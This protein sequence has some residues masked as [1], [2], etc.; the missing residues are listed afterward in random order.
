MTNRDVHKRIQ[1]SAWVAYGLFTAVCLLAIFVLD[2]DFEKTMNA[3]AV[4]SLLAFFEYIDSDPLLPS[5]EMDLECEH[6]ERYSLKR[7]VWRKVKFYA[8]L[9]V[10]V[11]AVRAC[12]ADS[13]KPKH[14]IVTPVITSPTTQP[15]EKT[16]CGTYAPM[17]RKARGTHEDGYLDGFDDAE[18]DHELG[19]E[20]GTNYDDSGEDDDYDEGY[21][22]GYE[23]DW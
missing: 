22:E 12:F 20:Y 11:L 3:W 8:C 4:L 18:L 2:W 9:A 6:A 23:D 17:G 5:Y 13:G 7:L 21:E 16:E 10:L 15:K 19:A 14:N 1:T